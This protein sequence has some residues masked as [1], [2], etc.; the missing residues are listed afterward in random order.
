[1]A[2]NFS[3]TTLTELPG[4]THR[5]VFPGTQFLENA[6]Q[7]LDILRSGASRSLGNIVYDTGR[8]PERNLAANAIPLSRNHLGILLEDLTENRRT[9]DKLHRAHVALQFSQN[10]IIM[11]NRSGEITYA[12]TFFLKLFGYA[13]PAEVK[14]KHAPGLFASGELKTMTQVSALTA[15]QQGDT[16]EFTLQRRDGSSFPAEV[17]SPTL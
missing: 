15:C 2:A 1:M 12:N 17:M 14:G 6:G 16:T 11:T 9:A 5:D 8:V 4:K 3:G 13:A 10:G 7:L